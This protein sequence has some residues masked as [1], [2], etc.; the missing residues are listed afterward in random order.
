VAGSILGYGG[1]GIVS[2][3]ADMA[4]WAI[5]MDGEKLL[6][7][8]TIEEA[9]APT[10]LNGGGQSDYGL[11]WGLGAVNGHRWVGHGGAHMTGFT[12]SIVK[13]RDDPIGVVVLTNAR[14]A[15]PGSIARVIAGMEVP[16]LKPPARKVIEDKEPKTAELVR[17]I[18]TQLRQ[19]KVEREKFTLELW[20]ILSLQLRELQEAAKDDGEL[21]AVELLER[22]GGPDERTSGYRMVFAN[23]TYFVRLTLN[24]A[25]KISGL[26]AEEE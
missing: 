25:G 21:K 20:A 9:W 3:A 13:Y 12:S 4:K 6:K 24:A 10:K 16:A 11:G 8:A 2:T 23:R 26:W 22:S 15:N 5:A 19:G 14:H 1:G 7:R 18:S 17:E